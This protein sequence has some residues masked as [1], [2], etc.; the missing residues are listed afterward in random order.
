MMKGLEH[1]SYKGRLSEL[2]LFSLKK[3]QR[4][5]DLFNV[6][7]IHREG[8]KRMDQ[9]LLVILSD[10]TRG[11]GQKLLHSKFC[12]NM[13]ENFFTV[14]VTEHWKRLP[15]MVVGS[16]SLEEGRLEQLTSSCAFQLQ[17]FCDSVEGGKTRDNW[18]K[19]K[20]QRFRLNLR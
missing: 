18:H 11:S 6:S 3:S 7:S 13:R 8:V 20:L 16:P 14:R 19:L 15:R 9:V 1:L 5:G 10:R 17:P 12:L 2:E 4:R